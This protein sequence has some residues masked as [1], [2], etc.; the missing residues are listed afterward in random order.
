MIRKKIGIGLLLLSS[1]MGAEYHYSEDVT[2]SL[3]EEAAKEIVGE[4][5]EDDIS[6]K[7]DN[8][9][10]KKQNEVKTE[11]KKSVSKT[12]TKKAAAKDSEKKSEKKVTKK[13]QG[14]KKKKIQEVMSDTSV[15]PE[16]VIT[17]VDTPR[18]LCNKIIIRIPSTL[19]EGGK[20]IVITERMLHT[21]SI[22]GRLRTEEEII[23]EYC[24]Y[25]KAVNEYHVPPALDQAQ[26]HIESLKNQH[27]FGHKEIERIFRESGLTY[28]EGL[29]ELTMF[30]TN[31]SFLS[32]F[33]SSKVLVTDAEIKKYYEEHSEVVPTSYKIE[34]AFIEKSAVAQEVIDNLR[35]YGLGQD[36]ILWQPAYWIAEGDLAESKQFITKMHEGVVKV[37]DADD[38]WEVVRLVKKIETHTKTLAERYKEITEKLQYEKFQEKLEEFKKKLLEEYIVIRVN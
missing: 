1:Y 33:V 31:R 20:D 15:S 26:Q 29:Q 16:D 35:K 25:D 4:V 23:F 2:R 32:S 14:V 3:A 9:V 17:V 10:D 36:N 7:H 21:K 28:E 11:K 38:K 24:V 13:K 12:T 27:G 5:R 8:V 30:Y 19:L 22:D 18:T 37:I 34:K 6:E